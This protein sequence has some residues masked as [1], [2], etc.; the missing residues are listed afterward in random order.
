[1]KAD[2]WNDL[3]IRCEGPRIQIWVN[4]VQT[5]DYTETDEAIPKSGRLGLQI[6]G[7]EP[8]EAA[9]RNIRV[10]KLGEEKPG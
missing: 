1:V 2:D 8:A 6:H 4:G 3:V 10:K 9:Y 7:G 5:V